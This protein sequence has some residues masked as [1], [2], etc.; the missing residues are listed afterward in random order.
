[1][2]ILGWMVCC[3]ITTKMTTSKIGQQSSVNIANSYRLDD[4]WIKSRWGIGG[5]AISAPVQT[6]PWSHTASSKMDTG[7]LLRW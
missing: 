3:L 5:E 7:S 2:E 1:M 4:P 6:S